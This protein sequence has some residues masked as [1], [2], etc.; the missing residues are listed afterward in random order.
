MGP[1][2]VS[3]SVEIERKYAVP[4]GVAL[5]SLER[6][7]G[8]VSVDRRPGVHLDAVYLDTPDRALLAAGI[9]VRRRTG[10]HDEG[11]HVKLRGTAGRVELHAPIDPSDPESVPA[12]FA[13]A[14]R[15]RVRDRP[16]HP[17]AL[18]RTERRAV[19]V[20]DADGGGVEVVDDLV[21]ATDVAAGVLRSWR[22]WEAEQAEDS[23][24]C[25]ALL[26]RV[27]TAL[28][29]AGASESASPAKIAQAL[30]LV[31]REPS[32]APPSTAGWIVAAVVAGHV[33]EL[34]RGMQSLALDGDPEGATVHEL[35]KV[36]RR[37]RAVLGLTPVAGPAG[38]CSARC[39]TRSSPPGSPSA[40]CPASIPAPLGSGRRAPCSST[41]RSRGSP[42]R[43]ERSS[44]AS[45]RT[46]C[47][48]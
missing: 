23:T 28:R 32:P 15:S 47:S 37:A 20:A 7:A 9:V 21:T 25:A 34:H 5:P 26:E 12:D 31:G 29:G 14:L 44:P 35:R 19:V 16:L 36:I 8:I 48:R 3:R 10:G 41:T 17:I 4:E 13:A 11:W 22:E 27:D 39:A 43:P 42:T 30:G 45:A 2:S 38:D 40:C 1:V 33:E 18:I 24:A 46:T 6:V